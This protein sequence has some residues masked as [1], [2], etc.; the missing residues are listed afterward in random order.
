VSNGNRD[1]TIAKHAFDF[2]VLD[3]ITRRRLAQSSLDL[4]QAMK[5]LDERINVHII[6]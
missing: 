5:L 1:A 2:R 6:R 3:D 4:S